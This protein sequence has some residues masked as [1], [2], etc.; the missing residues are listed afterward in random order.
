M[1][2]L[3]SE[4]DVLSGF[5]SLTLLHSE[6]KLMDHS[7]AILIAI[8]H[9]GLLKA[10]Q[11]GGRVNDN[12]MDLSADHFLFLPHYSFCSFIKNPPSFITSQPQFPYPPPRSLSLL[13]HLTP[14]QKNITSLSLTPSTLGEVTQA[15]LKLEISLHL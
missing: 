5:T 11:T 9:E 10:E 3:K 7:G 1:L 14:P 6:S 13:T 4:K 12:P 2:T 8:I 15:G